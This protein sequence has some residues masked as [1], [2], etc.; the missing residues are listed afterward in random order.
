MN[1]DKIEFQPLPQPGGGAVHLTIYKPG[2]F[3]NTHGGFAVFVGGCGWGHRRTLRTAKTYLL[4][5]ARA[6]CQRKIDAAQ[7]QLD[8]YMGQLEK[9]QAGLPPEV[10]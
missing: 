7:E 6:Y 2:G 1:N 4:E 5:C 8:Y 10:K 9:L 3:F